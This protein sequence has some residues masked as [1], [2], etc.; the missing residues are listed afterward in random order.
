MNVVAISG[1]ITSDPE[2]KQTQDGTSVCRFSVAV[3]R[4]N[5]KDKMDFIDCI[6]CR[7]KAEFVS[8]FF[9]KGQRI[10][11]T[12]YLTARKWEDKHGAKRVSHEVICD[13]VTFGDTKKKPERKA[14]TKSRLLPNM[15]KCQTTAICRF[16]RNYENQENN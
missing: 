4:P 7:Q 11:V 12:G 15:K 5:V 8:R 13:E 3:R 16:R 10:E 14:T 9:R 1:R 2:L 6:A